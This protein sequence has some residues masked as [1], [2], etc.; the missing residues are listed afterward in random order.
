MPRPSRRVWL[1]L[2]VRYLMLLAVV[3]LVASSVYAAADAA[4]RPTVLR[5]AVAAIV[6]VI[7]IHLYRHL[8]RQ[9]DAAPSSA[10]DQARS[11]PPADPMVPRQVL[12]L[13]ESVQ[14]SVRSQ[15]YFRQSLWPRLVQLGE[16]RGLRDPLQEPRGR[17]WL[18]RGPSLAAISEVVKRIE[19]DGSRIGD[20]SR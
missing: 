7:L 2:M 9:L 17:P 16:E 18:R 4:W 12:R 11:A 19:E 3:A 1:G 10:F 6:S 14:Y 13:Q 15:R 8:R 5:L 20:E